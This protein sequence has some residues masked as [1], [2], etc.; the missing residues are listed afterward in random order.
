MTSP[1]AVASAVAIPI[2]EIGRAWMV[3]DQTLARGAELGMTEPLSF[4]VHGRAG[5]LGDVDAD[6]AAAGIAFMASKRVRELWEGNVPAGLAPRERAAEYAAAAGRWA[7]ETFADVE[8]AALERITQ[9]SAH[10]ALAADPSLG[11]LFAG[12]RRI[13]LPPTPA[14]AAVVAIN[15]I[16][17]MRGAAHII[18]VHAVGLGPHGAIMSTDDP[19]RGG[20][21][22]AERFGWSDPHPGADSEKRANAELL[23]TLMTS[24]PFDVI[25][26]D[27]RSEY[28][29]LISGLRATLK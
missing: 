2:V 8:T 9:L 29:E 27:E 25:G 3:A 20:L 14:G 18:A 4:W 26:E 15:A 10:V 21:A 13:Q 16:R 19:V 24:H 22:G 7:D 17:E 6:V 11:T 12:W 23:T 1:T 28:V 5:V